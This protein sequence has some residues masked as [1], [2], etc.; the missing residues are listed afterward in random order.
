MAPSSAPVL[1][2]FLDSRV[3]VIA[4]RAFSESLRG[5]LTAALKLLMDGSSDSS[6][7]DAVGRELSRAQLLHLDR[8]SVESLSLLD[9]LLSSD[10]AG[11]PEE[12][13]LVIE[14]DRIEVCFGSGFPAPDEVERRYGQIDRRRLLGVKFREGDALLDAAEASHGGKNYESLPVYNALLFKAYRSFDWH[15]TREMAGHLSREL[16]RLEQWVQAGFCAILS[17]SEEV[18]QLVAEHL[19]AL[20]DASVVGAVVEKIAECAHLG[21]HITCACHFLE[22]LGD[23]VPDESITLWLERLRSARCLPCTTL[24]EDWAAQPALKATAVLL[25][26]ASATEAR[27]VVT[28]ILQHRLWSGNGIARDRFYKVLEAAA[29]VLDRGGCRSLA[30]AVLPHVIAT[31]PDHD[32]PKALNILGLI[33]ERWP[34]IKSELRKKIYRRGRAIPHMLVSAASF[35]DQAIKLGD[36]DGAVH[37]AIAHLRQQVE[38]L[39]PGVAAATGQGEFMIHNK[40]T[41][42]GSVAVKVGSCMEELGAL[43]QH[44]KKL[45]YPIKHELVETVID[46]LNNPDNVN[47]NRDGLFQILRGLSDSIDT[48]TARKIAGISIRYASEHRA[49]SHPLYGQEEQHSPLNPFRF[50]LTWPQDVRGEAILT[51]AQ[52]ARFHRQLIASKL[53]RLIQTGIADQNAVVRR[54]A[55]HAVHIAGSAA[56][57][58]L[59]LVVG[60]IRDSDATTSNVALQVVGAQAASIVKLKLVPTVL[61][62]LESHCRHPDVG[63]RKAIAAVTRQMQVALGH[64]YAAETERLKAL[65]D[66]LKADVSRSVRTEVSS[67]RGIPIKR[68]KSR[69]SGQAI[70][71]S[72]KARK[73]RLKGSRRER[74]LTIR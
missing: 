46:T 45:S 36:A 42:T 27:S 66:R 11:L 52:L 26:G 33:A 12:I 56:T 57:T 14:Q 67:K 35:F 69:S 20:N 22:K 65:S 72:S 60:G 4:A 59:S 41:A 1:A 43:V 30:K 47:A 29:A 21:R 13:R 58:C 24:A 23:A 38:A 63:V 39:A 15:Q 49:H 17:E 55:Y 61:T 34:A 73:G 37:R 8:Q 68:R 70:S 40:P 10:L 6:P 19:R 5:R 16:V 32:F 31:R 71:K 3:R 44:R 25:E 53:V 28:E 9:R 62:F 2:D 54:D 48:Q 64:R 74:P 18:A 7:A 51:L 50:G